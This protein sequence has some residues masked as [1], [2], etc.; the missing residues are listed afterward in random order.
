MVR[1]TPPPPSIEDILDQ[2]VAKAS[3]RRI[4]RSLAS[5][6]PAPREVAKKETSRE[7]IRRLAPLLLPWVFVRRFR[8]ALRWVRAN[9]LSAQGRDEEAL[10]LLRSLPPEM[11]AR[12][13]WKVDEIRQLEFLRWDKEAI[14]K[15]NAFL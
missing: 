15:A 7:T 10:R 8:G 9:E 1:I 13:S 5:A 14:E 6:P 3:G 11:Q 2:V 4:R 12:A